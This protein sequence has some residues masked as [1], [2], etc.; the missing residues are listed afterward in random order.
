[1]TSLRTKQTK[2]RDFA[3]TGANFHLMRTRSQNSAAWLQCRFSCHVAVSHYQKLSHGSHN[4]LDLL[5]CL[6]IYSE[7]VW[8]TQKTC[9][10]RCHIPISTCLNHRFRSII[11]NPHESTVFWY[12]SRTLGGYPISQGGDRSWAGGTP[13]PVQ[14]QC[15]VLLEWC[16][17]CIYLYHVV[18]ICMNLFIYCQYII[19][20]LH[21]YMLMYIMR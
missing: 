15:L 7:K 19:L 21:N 3:W 6:N 2:P 1:M 10:H 20:Y 13:S 9:I 4:L 17:I 16:T 12:P 5:A 8:F 11:I 18:S 14:N